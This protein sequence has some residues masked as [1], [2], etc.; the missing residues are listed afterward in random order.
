MQI[1]VV[2]VTLR[3]EI[4]NLALAT[5]VFQLFSAIQDAEN[6]E[7]MKTVILYSHSFVDQYAC[8]LP[9]RFCSVHS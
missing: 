2:L 6:N 3:V 4:K 5:A 9:F 8:T 1:T 7:A